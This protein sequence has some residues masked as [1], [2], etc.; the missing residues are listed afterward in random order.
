MIPT[1]RPVADGEW[2]LVAWLWQAYRSD[3]APIVHGLPYAD[4]RYSHGTL[5]G[6]PAR[7]R[8]GYVAWQPHPNTSEDA[9]V[10]FALV[11]GLDGDRRSMDAFWTAPAGRRDGL[12]LALAAHVLTVHPGPWT[13]AFQHDNEPA[14]GFWRRVAAE[15]FGSEG[16]GW[17]EE[18]RPVPGKPDVPPDHW[19]E[20][21]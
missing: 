17:S 15:H 11:S 5:D 16:E 9:P 8:A 10:G 20:S 2:E 19:I 7:D 4:G 1:I 3:M 21:V 12:G 18:R 13:V 14:R 6:Y